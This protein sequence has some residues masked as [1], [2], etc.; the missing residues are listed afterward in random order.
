MFADG[1]YYHIYNRGIDRRPTFINK[2]EYTR[3]LDLLSFYQHE[4]IPLRYSRFIEA[5]EERQMMYREEM[6]ASRKLIEVVAYCLMPNHFHLLIKQRQEQG[7]PIYI[8]NFMNAYTKYFNTKYQRTG[9][10]FQ[11][12]FKAV[13]VESEEQ[14]I[15]LVRYIHLNPIASNL[16]PPSELTTFPWS[17]HMHYLNKTESEIVAHDTIA[18]VHS[19]IPDYERFVTDQISYAQE[20]EKIKH[21]TF[22]HD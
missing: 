5:P 13:H 17:S 11:G 15:H 18:T 10:L 4:L 7:I 6:Q 1:E 16:I 12:I 3:A 9:K 20:L 19:L 8:S 22:E 2:R 14:L 21:M